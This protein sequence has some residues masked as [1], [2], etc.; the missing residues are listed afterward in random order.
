MFLQIYWRPPVVKLIG[1]DF[2]MDTPHTADNAHQ[3]KK[4]GM[5]RGRWTLDLTNTNS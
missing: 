5:S 1:H 3:R 4:Q 2:E